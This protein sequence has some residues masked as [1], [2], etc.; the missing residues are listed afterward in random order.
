MLVLSLLLFVVAYE[1]VKNVHS[2]QISLFIMGILLGTL[3][4]IN[5]SGI[6]LHKE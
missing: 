6:V 4:G 3:I 2:N 5:F 1:T